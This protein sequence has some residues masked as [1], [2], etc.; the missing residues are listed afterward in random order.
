[1]NKEYRLELVSER[2]RA[3]EDG[4]SIQMQGFDAITPGR[5]KVFAHGIV[6]GTGPWSLVPLKRT[7]V[8]KLWVF[9]VFTGSMF[10]VRGIT[11]PPGTSTTHCLGAIEGSEETREEDLT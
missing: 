9:E 6:E 4:R 3:L 7:C 10:A 11:P 1:M 2:F 8:T 5:H